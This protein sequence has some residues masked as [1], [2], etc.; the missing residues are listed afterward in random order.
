[1][2]GGTINAQYIAELLAKDWGFYHTA[3]TNLERVK[4]ELANVAALSV[5]QRN[6]I[7]EKVDHIVQIIEAEPKSRKWKQ[8]AKI[9]TRKLW[10]NEVSDLG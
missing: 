7:G 6:V 8:R 10:Y 9:G 1:V 5:E 4:T 2:E 3:T